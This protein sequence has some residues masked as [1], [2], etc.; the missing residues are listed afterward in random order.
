MIVGAAGGVGSA[1]V[2]IAKARGAMVIAVASSRHNDFLK[3]IGADRVV[4]YDRGEKPDAQAADVVIN[5]APGQTQIALSYAKRGGVLVS[6][7]GAV[8]HTAVRRCRGDLSESDG[9]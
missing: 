8:A 5:T 1:A 4:N 9:P 6:I 3:Q 7:V 2:Q